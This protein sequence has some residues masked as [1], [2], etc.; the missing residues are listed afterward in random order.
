MAAKNPEKRKRVM[1]RSIRLG[2]CVCDPEKTCPCPLFVEKDICTCA[3]ERLETPSGPVQLTRQL[4]NPGCASKIDQ[5]ALKKVLEGLPE[6]PDDPR[7]LVGVPAGDDAGIFKISEDLALVQTVDVFAPSVDDPYIFGQIAAANSISDVYAMGSSPISALS[8]VGFPI[9]EMDDSIM[10]EILRGGIDKMNEANVPVI[11]GHSINDRE[12]KAGFAVTGTINPNRIMTNAGARPGDVLVLTKPIGTGI[13]AFAA[14]IDRA[15]DGASE[16]ISRSMASLNRAASELMMEFGAHACTDITGFGLMG[17]LG[18]MAE[19]SGVDV[20]VIWDDIPLFPGV[21]YCL[22]NGIIP[23]GVEK[24]RESS[25]HHA[26]LGDGVSMLMLELCFDPQTSGGLMIAVA[27]EG[28]EDFLRRL[29]DAGVE[30]AAV[31]GRITAE[32]TGR[33]ELKTNGTRKLPEPEEL[34]PPAEAASV[35]LTKHKK[36]EHPVEPEMNEEECCAPE[37]SAAPSETA[38][39]PEA[40]LKSFKDFMQ[41][42]NA[43]GALDV[44]TK[45]AVAVA[46]SLLARCGPCVKAHIKKAKSMGFTQQE[47]DE[48]ANQ[49]ISFGGSVVMMFYKELKL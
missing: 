10:R 47:I 16:A 2:H 6:Q 19:S 48:L 15:P 27:E 38:A 9:D 32:G 41:K 21:L 12:I 20:Q 49:A 26:V 23:G 11:G 3:G 28:V 13:I 1:Q 34:K 7:V 42:A 37:S 33:V 39:A 4:D 25:A 18:E 14:Q 29:R 46:L 24:N 35:S 43:P 40:I 5:A 22:A 17:H 30:E 45:E 8:I 36:E 31:I 44:T